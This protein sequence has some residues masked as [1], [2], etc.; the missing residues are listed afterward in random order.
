M[1]IVDDYFVDHGGTYEYLMP[2]EMIII[3]INI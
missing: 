3:C 2:S 1:N